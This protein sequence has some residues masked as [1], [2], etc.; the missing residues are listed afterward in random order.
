MFRGQTA[1]HAGFTLIEL[2]LVIALLSLL[3]VLALPKYIELSREARIAALEQLAGAVWS[4]A[5]LGQAKCAVADTCNVNV[6]A[7]STDTPTPKAVVDGKE[8]VFH[9]GYP[10]AWDGGPSQGLMVLPSCLI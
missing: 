3:A 4:A 7:R 9:Y 6:N 2:V 5:T 8:I 10:N 1:H